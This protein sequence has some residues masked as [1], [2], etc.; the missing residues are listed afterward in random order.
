MSQLKMTVN[1]VTELIRNNVKGSEFIAVDLEMPLDSKMNKGG[2]AAANRLFGSGCYQKAML[3][4][5]LAGKYIEAVNRML[6]RQCQKT[7]ETFEPR[8]AK[9]HPWGDLD[10]KRVFRIH[11]TSG[12]PYLHLRVKNQSFG[13]NF[14]ANGKPLTEEQ[15][16]IFEKYKKERKAYGSSTQDGLE[17]KVIVKDFSLANIK[18]IRMRGVEIEVI[19]E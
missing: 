5:N 6:K 1:Q 3:N 9:D 8:T 10:S 14:Q 15:I 4:G 18:A 2:K 7:G 19:Q 13:G 12:L 11:R 17:N 16:E